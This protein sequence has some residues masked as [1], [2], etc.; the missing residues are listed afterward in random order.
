MH[1]STI[2]KKK[3]G[4]STQDLI[5]IKI[6][7]K[8]GLKV[9]KDEL[10]FYMVQPTNISVLS[11]TN[12]EIKVRH[13][14]MVLSAVPDIEIT[15]T[16]SCECFDTNKSYIKD[17]ID[18]EHNEKVR[19]ILAKDLDFLDSI[20]TETSTARQF[21]F[22][23][24][25]KSTKSENVL[26]KANRVEKIISDQ[27]FEVTRMSKGDIKRFLAIYFEASMNGDLIPDY[28]GEQYFEKEQTYE[29]A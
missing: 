22:I 1:K 23:A 11:H 12:I 26:Q 20:Q 3:R 7:T 29:K 8:N 18:D 24:R 4:K 16:D 21:L 13:L 5:G 27:G 10:I 6:F 28:D 19:K 15:C 14:M 17:R 25:C 2:R 9:G